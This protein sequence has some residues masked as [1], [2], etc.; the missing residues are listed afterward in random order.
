[1]I[2]I[3][4]VNG[5]INVCPFPPLFN[6]GEFFPRK[7]FYSF[8]N[9]FHVLQVKEITEFEKNIQTGKERKFHL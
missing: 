2:F 9:I 3:E 4:F 7:S 6:V 8:I 1:M 5:E